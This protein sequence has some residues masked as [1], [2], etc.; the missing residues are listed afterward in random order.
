[1]YRQYMT[2]KC[3]N[4]ITAISIIVGLCDNDGG[5]TTLDGGRGSR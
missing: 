1:M 4:T 2:C 3:K 5:L